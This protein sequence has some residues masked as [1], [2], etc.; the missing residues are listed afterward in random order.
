MPV[1]PASHVA[2]RKGILLVPGRDLGKI[3]ELP[4]MMVLRAMLA[5]TC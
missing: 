2:E 1:F 5:W 4:V 3:G